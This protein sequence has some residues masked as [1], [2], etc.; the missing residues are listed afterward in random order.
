MDVH[1]YDVRLTAATLLTYYKAFSFA[2]SYLEPDGEK[3]SRY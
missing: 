1:M 3:Q 2:S